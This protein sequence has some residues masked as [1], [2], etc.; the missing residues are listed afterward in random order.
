[1]CELLGMC[2]NTSV[3]PTISF[4]GFRHRG[5]NN[6]DGWG[7][8]FYPD[9]RAGQIIKEPIEAPKSSLAGF[10]SKYP[11]KSK[12][13]IC[14]VRK[15]TSAVAYRNTHPFLRELNGRE[16]M[17]AHNGVLRQTYILKGRF[18]PVGETD[19]ELAF[20]YIMNKIA[21]KEINQWISE[22]YKW[23]AGILSEINS[24]SSFNCLFSDGEQLFAYHDNHGYNGLCFRKR[25]SPY[26]TIKLMDE[27][28]S[29]NLS[30]EKDPFQ[31]GYI[32]T[33]RKLTDEP[34]EPFLTG[35]LIVFREGEIVFS[36]K[37]DFEEGAEIL[38]YDTEAEV[39]K[40]IRGSPRRITMR[41]IAEKL[42]PRMSSEEVKHCIYA[43]LQRGFIRQDGRD[44]VKWDDDSATF[45]TVPE[46]RRDIDRIIE[47]FKNNRT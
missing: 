27:D 36:S 5:K 37:R 44:K 20:C 35:E 2:F 22:D 26:A 28:W 41:E 42:M 13:F 7:L 16:Y 11:L 21:E 18:T 25:V 47:G 43:L 32:I 6:P 30:E 17:F 39:I 19:S 14:H 9:G 1:M 10:I 46:K 38:M 33:T 23:L 3:S 34:W 15:A 24:D 8:G 4:R 45:Y 40:I 29:I 12:I 31:R